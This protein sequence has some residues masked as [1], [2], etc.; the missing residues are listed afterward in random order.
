MTDENSSE[1]SYRNSPWEMWFICV[2]LVLVCLVYRQE[3][4]AF[5]SAKWAT[6]SAWVLMAIGVTIAQKLEGRFEQMLQRLSDRS[7]LSLSPAEFIEFRNQMRTRASTA[8]SVGGIALPA[9]LLLAYFLTLSSFDWLT[10]GEI[11]VELICALLVGRHAGRGVLYGFLGKQLADEGIK[12]N[13]ILGHSDHAAGLRPI[14]DFY[15]LQAIIAALPVVFFAFWVVM[16]PIWMATWP[17]SDPHFVSW[18]TTYVG[19]L[20][21]ALVL[22][23]TAF[24]LPM[25]FFHQQMKDQKRQLLPLADQL[26][27]ELSHVQLER[28]ARLT[29]L[30]NPEIEIPFDT[31]HVG[32]DP[33]QLVD[34]IAL[35]ESL[36]T[37]PL[38]PQIRNR[39]A[40]GNLALL[41]PG[42]MK[43]SQTVSDAISNGLK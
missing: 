41:A 34:Q 15:F 2:G 17:Q 22:E 21:I 28:T 5:S 13:M 3:L 1:P 24:V 36:P 26:S 37:W 16:M 43:L 14:G 19:F 27:A 12:V 8:A 40:L 30:A 11:F 29:A 4:M 35:L 7:A 23:L 32:A 20:I 6:V 18:K 39:F 33:G 31:E 42:A 38:A 9:L 10:V 25:L